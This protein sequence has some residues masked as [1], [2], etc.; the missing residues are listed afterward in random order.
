MSEL[1]NL[2]QINVETLQLSSRERYSSETFLKKV[3]ETDEIR[4]PKILIREIADVKIQIDA[5][6]DKDMNTGKKI[7]ELESDIREMQQDHKNLQ[8][9]SN[10]DH[11]A[12]NRL[13]T[14]EGTMTNGHKELSQKIREIENE[15]R[16]I[17]VNGGGN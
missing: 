14:M 16:R 6:K 7:V 15:M 9:D 17:R 11:L 4:L 2:L 12:E 8:M 1:Q 5:L 3:R 10:R 13:V